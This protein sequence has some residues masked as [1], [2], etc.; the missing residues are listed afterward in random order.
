VSSYGTCREIRQELAVYVLGSIEPGDRD[1]VDRHLAECGG[2]RGELAGMAGLPALLRRV[3]PE[4]AFALLGGER[5]NS[6]VDYP[7]GPVLRHR[8]ALASSSRR[9]QMRIR[10]AAAAAVGLVG[11]AGALAG[12]QAAHPSAQEMASPAAG[13]GGTARAAGPQPGASA[14][15]R[16]A[17]RPWGIRLSVQIAGIP[18]GTTCQLKVISAAAPATSAGGWII[19][20]GGASWYPASSPVPLTEVR[21]FEVTSGSKVLVKVPIRNAAGPVPP[22]S[23]I[24]GW[25]AG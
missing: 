24:G 7:S 20:R 13:W 12:W 2:C 21:G 4:E 16:Y 25:R 18:V 3:P 14:A 11:G 9:R 1:V 10:I 17:S 23:G 6:G 19:S 8:L 22:A 5:G 15:V